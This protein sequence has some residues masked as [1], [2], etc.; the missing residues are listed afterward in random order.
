[1]INHIY[2]V[3]YDSNSSRKRRSRQD[4]DQELSNL[5]A[6]TMCHNYQTYR[7][8]VVKRNICTIGPRYRMICIH[9]TVKHFKS[10]RVLIWVFRYVITPQVIV[11]SGIVLKM[12]FCQICI[13]V[14]L[15]K[16]RSQL[17]DIMI[18]LNISPW[19]FVRVPVN[20]LLPPRQ[21]NVIKAI[22]LPSPHTKHNIHSCVMKQAAGKYLTLY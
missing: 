13:R 2:I 15:W 5:S 8:F 22:R 12:A 7:Q 19:D 3:G 18:Y 9:G 14:V 17:I 1:M 4:K 11:F 16:P 6:R 20:R 10:I 21:V